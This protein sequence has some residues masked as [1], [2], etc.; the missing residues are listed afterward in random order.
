MY[1]LVAEQV[2]LREVTRQTTE[3]PRGDE[4]VVH[5]PWTTTECRSVL[6]PWL[7]AGLIELWIDADWPWQDD[8]TPPQW[9][10]RAERV[11]QF[12]VLDHRDAQDLL[13]DPHRWTS[14]SKDSDVMLSAS[15]EGN[16]CTPDQWAARLVEQTD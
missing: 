7:A 5:G 2:S 6:E 3:R 16:R 10:S 1:A 8:N 9:R 14:E 4:V 15:E 13:S 11:G 12:L